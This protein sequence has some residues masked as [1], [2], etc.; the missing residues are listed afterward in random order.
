MPAPVRND[1]VSRSTERAAAAMAWKPPTTKAGLSSFDH[2]LGLLGR[3]REPATAV[4]GDI[5]GRGLG[6]EP[7]TDGALGGLGAGRQLTGRLRTTS[8]ERAIEA[9]PVADHDEGTVE[10]GSE[11]ADGLADERSERI[12]VND[13]GIGVS[14]RGHGNAPVVAGDSTAS[15]RLAAAIDVQPCPADCN[16]PS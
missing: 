10:D 6:A 5:A 15:V 16:P 7:S 12:L 4:I 11:G 3:Q 14:G 9:E 2:R 8:G 1:T 13:G